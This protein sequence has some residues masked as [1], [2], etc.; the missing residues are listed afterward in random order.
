MF[1]YSE[2]ARCDSSAGVLG[3][4]TSFL[5]SFISFV[6][7]GSGRGDPLMLGIFREISG[8][9]EKEESPGRELHDCIRLRVWMREAFFVGK[10]CL[11]CSCCPGFGWG[12]NPP[13]CCMAYTKLADTTASFREC[14]IVDW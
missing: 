14:G 2:K 10:C 4:T 6:W 12:D 1:V 11:F 13:F 8:V 7:G 5:K 9:N 3:R